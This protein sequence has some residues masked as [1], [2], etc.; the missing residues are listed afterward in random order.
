MTSALELGYRLLDTAVNYGNETEVG[1]A[2]RRAEVDRDDVLVCS[3]LPGRHHAHDD[4]IRST[5]ESLDRLGLDHLDLHLIHWPNPSVG[6]YREAWRALVAMREEGLVRDIGVSNFTADHLHEVIDD[7]GVVPLVNQVELHPYFP[8]VHL[9]AVHEEL[10][11]RTE[12]WSPLAKQAVFDEPPITAAA[13]AHG[14]SPGQVVLR[15]HQHLRAIPIPKSGSPDRQAENLALD[16]FSLTPDEVTAITDL[17][18][19]DG[20]LFDGDPR[21]HEEQ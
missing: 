18:R 1:E 14:V 21:F 8:Q 6:R 19:P 5:H 12:S 20:R 2:I 16:G 7:T 11:V 9:R 15:W 3:K 10:G 17:G 4:A 13:R